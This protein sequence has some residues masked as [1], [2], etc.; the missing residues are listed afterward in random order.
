[1]LLIYWFLTVF[2]DDTAQCIFFSGLKHQPDY[3]G[4]GG[5]GGDSDYCV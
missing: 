5:E 3:D 4:D 1:M 2:W